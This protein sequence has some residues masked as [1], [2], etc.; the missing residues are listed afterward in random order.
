MNH[1]VVSPRYRS[2]MT[3]TL[4]VQTVVSLFAI[5]ALDGGR[6]S[7]VVG[8]AMLGFWLV[9]AMILTRRPQCPK[10]S[11]LAWIRWGFWPILLAAA[12]YEF[13]H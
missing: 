3:F 6:L 4:I 7:R 1:E 12:W 10:E 11:D 5:L 8:V 13:I 9:T 2:D